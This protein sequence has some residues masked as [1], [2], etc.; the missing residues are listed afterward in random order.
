MDAVM[1]RLNSTI[2]IRLEASSEAGFEFLCTIGRFPFQA[3]CI[4]RPC[5]NMDC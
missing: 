4:L 3:Q 2:K 1:K 5:F